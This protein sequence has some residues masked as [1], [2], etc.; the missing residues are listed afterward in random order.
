MISVESQVAYSERMS[1]L[2]PSRAGHLALR[3]GS[4]VWVV[5]GHDES[6]AREDV[7]RYDIEKREWR[8]QPLRGKKAASPLPRL[9]FDGCYLGGAG[10]VAGTVFAPGASRIFVFGGVQ[11]EGEQ[12]L[13]LNDLWSLDCSATEVSWTLVAEETPCPERA[14]HVCVALSSDAMFVHGGDCMR[15]LDDAWIYLAP[16]NSWV[17]VSVAPGDPAPHARAQHSAAYCPE[18]ESVAIF[19]GLFIQDGETV[20]LNDLWLLHCPS[21]SLS[22]GAGVAS[23]QWTNIS[24]TDIAP[25]PRD[26][27]MLSYVDGAGLLIL[28][29]FGLR[30]LQ[31]DEQLEQLTLAE[32]AQ[33]DGGDDG[34][35]VLSYLDDAWLLRL[36]PAT[37]TAEAIEFDV[38]DVVQGGGDQDSEVGVE[39][40]EEQG[41]ESRVEEEAEEQENREEEEEPEGEDGEEEEEVVIGPPR[42]GCKLVNI[43]DGVLLSFGGFDGQAFCSE[44]E[45]IQISK[46]LTGLPSS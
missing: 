8:E 3:V 11:L 4:E 17:K 23:F 19:G 42:R 25:S 40:E 10:G 37:G 14:G 15:P 45:R 16:S 39:I 43:G 26:L 41:A 1:S 31:E 29:G 13:I 5:G 46:L 20:H 21:S 44:T 32:K 7:W 35:L 2:I 36:A 9:E 27:P 34:A 22:S 33:G 30:E 28:G 24:C 12:V 38:S 18:I 6:G